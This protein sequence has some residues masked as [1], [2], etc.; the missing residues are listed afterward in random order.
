MEQFKKAQ[1]LISLIIPKAVMDMKSGLATESRS[2]Q[3]QQWW[4]KQSYTLAWLGSDT[5]NLYA[6][7]HSAS[8]PPVKNSNVLHPAAARLLSTWQE[9]K[10]I[11][12]L[13]KCCQTRHTAFTS[14]CFQRWGRFWEWDEWNTRSLLWVNL[15]TSSLMR[16]FSSCEPYRGRNVSWTCSMRN[17]CG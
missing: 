12:D 3:G 8:P 5:H 13:N 11:K 15:M 9:I 10:T 16:L 14:E 7:G 1:R 6:L 17:N 4:L 2:F